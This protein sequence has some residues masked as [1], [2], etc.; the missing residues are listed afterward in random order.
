MYGNQGTAAPHF[1]AHVYCRQTAGW[2]KMPFGID[3]GGTCRPRPHCVRWEPTC[4]IS[5]TAAPEF[6][7]VSIV[8]KWLDGSNATWY[9]SRPQRKRHCV[10]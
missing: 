10:R 8:A 6:R 1:L 5:G 4:P 9:G 3:Y 7:P 2:I